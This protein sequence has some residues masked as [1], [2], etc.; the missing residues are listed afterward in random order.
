MPAPNRSA[1]TDTLGNT[2]LGRRRAIST[3]GNRQGLATLY[4]FNIRRRQHRD[5]HVGR[6]RAAIGAS[7]SASTAGIA[8]TVAAGRHGAEPGHARHDGGQ[9]GHEHGGHDDGE[10]R[11]DLRRGDGRFRELRH[12]H[13]RDRIHAGGPPINGMDVAT[14]DIDPGCGRIQSPPPSRYSRAPTAIWPRWRPSK[15]RADGRRRQPRRVAS[16]VCNPTSRQ[17]RAARRRAPSP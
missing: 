7:S 3:R 16:L 13:R 11:P 4:A 14:E 17:P 12:D 6:D 1:Q 2:Y 15:A 5:G 9:R 8:T 10:R